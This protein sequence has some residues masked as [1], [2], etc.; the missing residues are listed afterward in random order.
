MPYN[1]EK[2]MHLAQST[3]IDCAFISKHSLVVLMITEDENDTWKSSPP[4]SVYTINYKDSELDWK[5]GRMKADRFV[6]P[7]IERVDTDD[8]LITDN[9]GGVYYRKGTSQ[10]PEK[11]IR[12]NGEILSMSD[13]QGLK[14]IHGT[15]YVVGNF[16]Q[17]IRRDAIAAWSDI[18]E[19]EIQEDAKKRYNDTFHL[20]HTYKSGFNCIDGFE[21]HENLY[22]AG[23]NSNVWKYTGSSWVPIDTGVLGEDII[24]ICCAEDGYVYLGTSTGRL[25]KGHDDSWEEI[26]TPF[27]EYPLTAIAYFEETIYLA[28]ENRLYTYN[29]NVINKVKYNTINGE[30][31]RRAGSLDVNHGYLLSVG[32]QSIAIYDGK[33]WQ[34]LYGGDTEDFQSIIDSV[35]N[36]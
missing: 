19:G 6:F 22:A 1:E 8:Y 14:N 28:T 30:V 34:I 32:Q 31:P 3:F 21:A 9:A 33:E 15:I 35:T 16:R 29:N 2:K 11:D 4:V 5:R 7:M 20:L 24:S 23:Q 26:K 12:I 17:V 18:S 27:K 13:L 36:N 25:I 10:I